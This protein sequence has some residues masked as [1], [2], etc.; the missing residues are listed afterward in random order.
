[1]ESD[2]ESLRAELARC[3]KR[4]E[5]AK[6]QEADTNA[7]CEHLKQ[8]LQQAQELLK[9]Q[10]EEIRDQVLLLQRKHQRILELEAQQGDSVARRSASASVERGDPRHTREIARLQ[11]EVDALKLELRSVRTIGNAGNDAALRELE[12]QLEVTKIEHEQEMRKKDEELTFLAEK[13][14]AAEDAFERSRQEIHTQSSAKAS[15]PSINIAEYE[16]LQDRLLR[17]NKEIEVLRQDRK[18]QSSTTTEL[19]EIQDVLRDEKQQRATESA[20]FRQEL[21]AAKRKISSLVEQNDALRVQ[22]KNH[23]EMLRFKDT[24]L[25]RHREMVSEMEHTT[26]LATSV[27]KRRDQELHDAQAA[28]SAATARLK[29]RDSEVEQLRVQLNRAKDELRETQRSNQALQDEYREL[30]GKEQALRREQQE[31]HE[32]LDALEAELRLQRSRVKDAQRDLEAVPAWKSDRNV[33]SPAEVAEIL[34]GIILHQLHRRDV[35]KSTALPEL[36]EVLTNTLEGHS[37]YLGR[38]QEFAEMANGL[39]LNNAEL[40]GFDAKILT[41]PLPK[42][43]KDQEDALRAVKHVDVLSSHV[44]RALSRPFPQSQQRDFPETALRSFDR[45]E[46]REP[47]TAPT[48]PWAAPAQSLPPRPRRSGSRGNRS[49]SED[50]ESSTHPRRESIM[51]AAAT[52]ERSRLNRDDIYGPTVPSPSA[53]QPVRRPPKREADAA[54][55]ESSDTDSFRPR[56]RGTGR[57]S[58]RATPEAPKHE[59]LHTSTLPFPQRRESESSSERR[60]PSSLRKAIPSQ[61][62]RARDSPAFGSDAQASARPVRRSVLP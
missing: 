57:G 29:D 35:A 32:T 52:A 20:R 18:A 28:A 45:N 1:M 4:L 11:A 31:H 30:R 46:I 50:S 24:E 16:A 19:R 56:A 2:T 40:S 8:Q 38:L 17:A 36:L 33:P 41:P 22:C 12:V 21:D 23:E 27:G 49:G 7:D 3:R 48:D 5:A 44:R 34:Q 59:S 26:E 58:Y 62:S 25:D 37:I 39:V 9:D 61:R 60:G 6:R 55:L 47:T 13:L 53:A 10:E 51:R 14:D 15:Q 54:D 43:A 42:E